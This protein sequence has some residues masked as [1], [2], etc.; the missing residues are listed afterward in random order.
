[1]NFVFT[2]Q[3][4]VVFNFSTIIK[5][6][7]TTTKNVFKF[8]YKQLHRKDKNVKIYNVT[9]VKH[10]FKSHIHMR[11]VLNALK[12]ENNFDFDHIF[13]FVNYKNALKFFY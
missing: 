11:R 1:M 10:D 12:N 9:D 7:R 13:E 8:D 5:S 2:F 4:F 6:S 3:L